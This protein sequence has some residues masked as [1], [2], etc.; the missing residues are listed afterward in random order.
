[1][2]FGAIDGSKSTVV[3]PAHDIRQVVFSPDARRVALAGPYR[4]VRLRASDGRGGWRLRPPP[5]AETV[6]PKLLDLDSGRM[7]V[8]L[9][10][11]G[12]VVAL[13]FSPNGR[14]L[15]TCGVDSTVLL[16]P[17]DVR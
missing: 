16:W 6:A 1:L 12:G 17:L 13:A 15:A 14:M 2:V 3:V 7:R 11:D 9:G 8:L 4:H 5:P 10:H